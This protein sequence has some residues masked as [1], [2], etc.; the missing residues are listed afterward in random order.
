M[1]DIQCK[2]N[3]FK[4]LRGEIGRYLLI[5][6]DSWLAHETLILKSSSDFV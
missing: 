6:Q 3:R 4:T 5:Q 1:Y 2:I